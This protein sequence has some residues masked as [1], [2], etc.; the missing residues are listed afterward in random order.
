[1]LAPGTNGEVCF[2][3]GGWDTIDCSALHAQRMY[4]LIFGM[5]MLSLDFSRFLLLAEQDCTVLSVIEGS[6]LKSTH[7]NICYL[8]PLC[9]IPFYQSM[10]TNLV[11]TR[12]I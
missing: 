5:C 4:A 3:K 9:K 11:R 8:M 10:A 7:E 2:L 12:S 1:M 6:V